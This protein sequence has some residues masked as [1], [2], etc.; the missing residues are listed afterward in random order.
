VQISL[1]TQQEKILIL[2]PALEAAA[3]ESGRKRAE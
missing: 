1:A 3:P 2:K